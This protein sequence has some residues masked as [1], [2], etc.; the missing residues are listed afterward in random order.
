[1]RRLSYL[2]KVQRCGDPLRVLIVAGLHD[3]EDLLHVM[4]PKVKSD[5]SRTYIFRPHPRARNNY[6]TEA[7][8]VPNL[9]VD[10]SPIHEVLSTVSHVF[11]T[12]SGL[13]FEVASIG[14]P[15]TVVNIPGR[16]Q[17]SK[18]FDAVERGYEVNTQTPLNIDFFSP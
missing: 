11:V 14:I 7:G 4:L 18:C 1:V 13:G 6:L 2:G 10:Q 17:W 8:R 9:I 12:Y 3:G 5:S 15:V 16:V